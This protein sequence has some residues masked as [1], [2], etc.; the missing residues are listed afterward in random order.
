MTIKLT[1][2]LY[3]RPVNMS[4]NLYTK[5]YAHRRLIK[6]CLAMSSI[7]GWSMGFIYELP[8]FRVALPGLPSVT[9]FQY[10]VTE[11]TML[12]LKF[13]WNFGQYT[14]ICLNFPVAYAQKYWN[15][16]KIM[17]KYWNYCYPLLKWVSRGWQPC[18]TL[19]G[20]NIWLPQCQW[21]NPEWYVSN[22]LI[23]SCN[24]TEQS[25]N[26]VHFVRCTVVNENWMQ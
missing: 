22:W 21:S 11:I 23:V 5:K 19:T 3:V 16:C 15:L 17:Q 26:G 6:V 12:L 10:F 4:L 7:L 25:A 1:S 18:F 14:E 24:N 9:E 13:S 2:N 8:R 20:T